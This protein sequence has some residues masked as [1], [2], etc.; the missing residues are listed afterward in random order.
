MSTHEHKD[1]DKI[2]AELKAQRFQMLEDIAEELAGEV[3]FPTHFDVIMR[4]RKVLNDPN[5]S[6]SG[7]AAA[8][9]LDPRPF[10]GRRTKFFSSG[11]L[12]IART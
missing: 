4:L 5:Q 10:R 6:I 12:E 11:S 8:V 7:I 1:S 2:G 9:S 3:V